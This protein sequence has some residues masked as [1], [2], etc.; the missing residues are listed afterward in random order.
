MRPYRYIA[1]ILLG[2]MVSGCIDQV[3]VLFYP[4]K[5]DRRNVRLIKNVSTVE[6]C[7]DRAI[8]LAQSIGD[9][10]FSD[11][12][13]A[14]GLGAA[15]DATF[16]RR[17]ERQVTPGWPDPLELETVD[18]PTQQSSITEIPGTSE[19]G[20]ESSAQPAIQ[21]PAQPMFRLQLA[22]Y[23]DYDDAR[24]FQ[25]IAQERLETYLPSDKIVVTMPQPSLF[26]VGIVMFDND[27]EPR[28]LCRSMQ[29]INQTCRVRSDSNG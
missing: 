26:E 25:M 18:E 3:D 4:D 12:D 8:Q 2:L 20:T 10:D 7:R 22:R 13:Y 23:E 19:G 29:V 15:D 11:S 6:Q 27:D 14:C 16:G 5:N 9:Q 28:D 17:Y 1:P 21:S 24:L